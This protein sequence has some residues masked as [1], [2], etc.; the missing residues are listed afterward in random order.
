M[1]E[2][3]FKI[4]YEKQLKN[5]FENPNDFKIS[6]Q[7]VLKCSAYNQGCDGGYSY[8]VSKFFN[9]FEVYPEKCWDSHAKLCHQECKDPKLSKL[10]LSVTDFYYV[11]GSYGKTN[12]E[13]LMADLHKNGPIVVSLEPDYSFMIYKNGVYDFNNNN[14]LSKNASKPQW[15]KVDHSVLLVGWGVEVADGKEIKYWL[16]QNSWGAHWGEKGFMRFKRGVDLSG[17][18]SIGEA[19]IPYLSE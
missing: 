19:A 12:E 14:W 2:A 3:R 15:Q 11:G 16:L 4:K 10:K 5:Y 7:H 1:I 17:I 6:V 8:L 13:N 18:E 9:Q